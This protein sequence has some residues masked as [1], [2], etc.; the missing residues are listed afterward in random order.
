MRLA[1][2]SLLAFPFLSGFVM[3]LIVWKMNRAFHPFVEVKAGNGQM[4][5]Y[6]LSRQFFQ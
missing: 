1:I 2:A 5:R 4:Y 6:P 3:A